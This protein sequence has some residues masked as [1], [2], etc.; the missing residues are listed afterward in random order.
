MTVTLNILKFCPLML[1]T[2]CKGDMDL[3]MASE[4]QGTGGSNVPP[5]GPAEPVTPGLSLYFDPES[6]LSLC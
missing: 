6:L 3:K 5:L 1:L 4:A 2:G